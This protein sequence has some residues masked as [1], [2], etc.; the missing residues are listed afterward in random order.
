MSSLAS[1]IGASLPSETASAQEKAYVTYA[2]PNH[3]SDESDQRE[4]AV[5][6]L[7]SRSVISSLG[8][9]G[10]RTWEAALHLGAFLA[11]ERGLT[12][13]RGKKVFELGAG[14]GMLSILCAKHLGVSGMVATDG[15]E[16]VVD[17]IKTNSFLNGLD[18]AGPSQTIVRTAVLRWGW[19]LTAATFSEDYGM[20]VPDVVVGADVVSST[21][22]YQG[23]SSLNPADVRQDRDSCTCFVIERVLRS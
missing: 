15:D 21:H 13:V 17:A 8:T 3:S 6:L 23:I 22:K 9:T 12:T 2:F 7:E 19:P 4:R 11:S 1:L 20:D 14:T 18:A 5:T 16:A 10:L